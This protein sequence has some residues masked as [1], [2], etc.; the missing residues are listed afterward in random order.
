MAVLRYDSELL[1]KINEMVM[2]LQYVSFMFVLKLIFACGSIALIPLAWIIGIVDKM[3]SLAW[4]PNLHSKIMNNY[5]FIVL[6]PVILMFDV[7]ADM[8]YFWIN[9]FR[10]NLK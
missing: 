6:G 5:S 3:V 10:T 8:Y 9:N 7:I 4:Q 2:K 1:N